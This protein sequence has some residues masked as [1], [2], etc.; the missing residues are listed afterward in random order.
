MRA[1]RSLIDFAP[2]D[3]PWTMNEGSH[4]LPASWSPASSVGSGRLPASGGGGGGGGEIPYGGTGMQPSPPLP[5]TTTPPRPAAVSPAT[6]APPALPAFP[7]TGPPSGRPS[8]PFVLW[9]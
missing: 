3:V 2:H 7:A 1:R 6:P 5:P 9:A 8:A 4:S